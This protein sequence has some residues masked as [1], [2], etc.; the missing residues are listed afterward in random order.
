MA[1][2]PNCKTDLSTYGSGLNPCGGNFPYD[3]ADGSRCP[4]CDEC[5]DDDEW[6]E[7]VADDTEPLTGVNGTDGPDCGDHWG[8]GR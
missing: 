2:C 7:D 4:E 8:V 3:Y 6:L 5:I 1:F